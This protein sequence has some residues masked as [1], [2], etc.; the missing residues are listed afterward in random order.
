MS[1]KPFK[2][3]VYVSVSFQGDRF[4]KSYYEIHFLYQDKITS[5]AA[6]SMFFL[7]SDT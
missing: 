1:Q 4:Y 5:Y 3:K 6:L 2:M 7:H